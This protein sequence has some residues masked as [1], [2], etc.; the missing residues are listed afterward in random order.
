MEEKYVALAIP[1]FLLMMAVEILLARRRPELQYVFADSVTNLSCG[2]GQ[3]VLEPLFRTLGLAAYIFLYERLRLVTVPA[4]SVVGWIALVLGV[5]LFYYAFHRASHRINLFWA[6]HVVHHQSE[7]Y[8]LSV[9]LRQSWLELLFSWVFYLPLAIAG[10]SPGAFVAMST[11][12]TLYQFWIHTRFV[13]RLPAPVEWVLN[14][15]SHHR[16]HHGTN[17]KYI[18]KNYGGILIVWDRIF[19]TF[20]EEEEEPVYGTVKPLASF[21]PL[22]AN[23]HYW[24]EMASMS[25]L[26]PRMADKVRAWIAPPEW[27][28]RE[29]SDGLGRVVI[30]EVS[31]ETQR[32]H[33]VHV[34]RGLRT[35]LR[36]ELALVILAAGTL[37]TIA[38]QAQTGLV[39]VIAGLVLV[40][41]I[42]WGALI[43]GKPWG[44]GLALG[45]MAATVALVVWC[46]RGASLA[47]VLI[48][49]VALVSA[50][51]ATWVL[52][53]RHAPPAEAAPAHPI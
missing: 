10:F 34:A 4:G 39:A 19:G 13:K 29:L 14:T 6:S 33:T 20:A 47:P 37:P 5:D 17:P 22:W 36:V 41:L 38:S 18:D 26:A 53:Y 43:E 3:Q 12:N 51:T 7:E 42:G 52:R 30:P 32:K 9:A 16:V 40:E 48:A 25:G 31:R 44:V 2:I 23:A 15:A 8:N 24:V 27:R 46:T 21:N 35:Y 49:A 11:L 1:F 50:V 28:P 45:R